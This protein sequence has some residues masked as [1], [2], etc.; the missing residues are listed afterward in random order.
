M[1][2]ELGQILGNQRDQA[3]IVGPRRY[4]AEPDLIALD[5]QL[6]AEDASPAQRLGDRQRDAFGLRHGRRTHRLRLPGFLIIAPFLAMTDWLTERGP[7]DMTDR[8][9]GV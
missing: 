4:L 2:G 5:E 8:K 1:Q 3:G 9:S 7:A 6:H